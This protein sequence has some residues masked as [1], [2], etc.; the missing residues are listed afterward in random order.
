MPENYPIK[1]KRVTI[2]PLNRD[3]NLREVTLGYLSDLRNGNIEDNPEN[4]ILYLSD[5]SEKDL[6]KLAELPEYDAIIYELYR[7]IFALSFGD[8]SMDKPESGKD[9]DVDAMIAAL[10]TRGHNEAYS[11][12]IHFAETVIDV[13][14]GKQEPGKDNEDTLKEAFGE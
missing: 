9:G 10:I 6:K 3:A 7:H 4:A 2:L 5:L 11:Y 14:S 1:T 8:G 13:L 12:G